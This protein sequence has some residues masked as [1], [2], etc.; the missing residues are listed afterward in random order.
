MS[1][2]PADLPLIDAARLD[3]VTLGDEQIVREL[4][5]A[6][7]EHLDKRLPDIRT[8]FDSQSLSDLRSTAHGIKGSAAN[9]GAPAISAAAGRIE[10]LL[11]EGSGGDLSALVADL[12]DVGRRTRDAVAAQLATA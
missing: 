5:T 7:L 11:I 10:R 12:L 8:Q 1:D 6:F 3:E 4:L 9:I 2:D